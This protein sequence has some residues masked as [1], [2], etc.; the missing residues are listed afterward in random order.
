MQKY[1][2]DLLC[3]VFESL[4]TT[5]FD[6]LLIY[7]TLYFISIQ[8]TKRYFYFNKC[9]Q[10]KFEIVNSLYQFYHYNLII[11]IHISQTAVIY[12]LNK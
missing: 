8:V 9:F 2:D 10:N 7:S 1:F 6:N 11:T 12:P 5:G 3:I 4:G